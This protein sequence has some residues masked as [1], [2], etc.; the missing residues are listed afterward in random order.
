MKSPKL[1]TL[2]F[3]PLLLLAAASSS[4]TDDENNK[5]VDTSSLTNGWTSAKLDFKVQYPYDLQKSD[6]YAEKDGTY[7]LWVFNTDQPFSKGNHTLPR[8]EMRFPELTKGQLQFEADMMSPT[9]TNNVCIMQI[10]TGNEQSPDYGS[11]TFML[12]VR[13]GSLKH[14]GDKTLAEGILDKWFHLN[15]IHDLESHTITAYINAKQVWQKK[16]NGANDF[17]FKCGVYT[18]RGG[19]H[20]MQVFIKNLKLWTKS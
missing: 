10:H 15:V 13:D 1:T 4:N 17:Y 11:T 8:T 16:D 20:E 14:Y 3:L 5:E 18:Q 9:G 6:R 19:S 12:D 7:H 2:L